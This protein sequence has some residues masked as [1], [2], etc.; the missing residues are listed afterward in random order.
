MTRMCSPLTE[1]V[2]SSLERRQPSG[3]AGL[4]GET[5]PAPPIC[6]WPD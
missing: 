6:L 5:E 4:R 2:E 1:E 3:Q